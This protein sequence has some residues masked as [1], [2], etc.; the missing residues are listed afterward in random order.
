MPIIFPSPS[1]TDSTLKRA[2]PYIIAVICLAVISCGF[3][4]IMM[5]AKATAA[6]IGQLRDEVKSNKEAKRRERALDEENAESL[7]GS[8][9]DDTSTDA[10]DFEL[11]NFATFKQTDP[12]KRTDGVPSSHT[13]NPLT[14]TL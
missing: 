7:M 6:V 1:L 8:A 4:Y 3:A 13:H 5:N 9:V 10:A 11:S 2:E 12:V 14:S